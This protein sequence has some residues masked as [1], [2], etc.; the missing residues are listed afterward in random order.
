MQFWRWREMR[1]FIFSLP[2]HIRCDAH[3]LNL[4]ATNEV[5]KT[6]SKRPS[7]S[8]P[9]RNGKASFPYGTRHTGHQQLQKQCKILPRWLFLFHVSQNGVYRVYGHGQTDWTYRRS[10][11]W[12]LWKARSDRLHPN[13]MTVREYVAV[14]Q[15]LDWSSTGP[16]KM[17]YLEFLIPTIVSFK[18]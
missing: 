6:V 15:P 10:A 14:L 7:Q 1:S 5:D 2:P 16:A 12:C 18:D 17:Y 8:V 9:E 13:E 3:T 11:G 4:T